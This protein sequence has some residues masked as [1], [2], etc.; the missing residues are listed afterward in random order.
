[1]TFS[2]KC[3]SKQS[4]CLSL[5]LPL[6]AGPIAWRCSG[7]TVV[8]NGAETPGTLAANTTNSYTFNATNGDSLVLRV[9]APVIN[10]RLVLLNPASVV[11]GLAG[12]GVSGAHEAYLPV[13]ATN[14]GTF[15]V[16]VSSIVA[17]GSGT[18]VLR[19]AK[20]PGNFV[21]SPGDEGGALANGTSNSGTNSL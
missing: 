9:G 18:Y 21:V 10:P 5:L 2:S 8:T 14:T 19:L 17:G 7:Q 3:F 12:S 4:A 15:T 11:I 16:Q 6:L 1:M 20:I 13:S